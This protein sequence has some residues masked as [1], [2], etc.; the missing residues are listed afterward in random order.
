MAAQLL[1]ERYWQL[2]YHHLY[3]MLVPLYGRRVRVW[4]QVGTVVGGDEVAVTVD[5][6]H[7]GKYVLTSWSQVTLLEDDMDEQELEHFDH[8]GRTFEEARQV[9]RDED[10]RA[11]RD[12]WERQEQQELDRLEQEQEFRR[13]VGVDRGARMEQ[14][15]DRDVDTPEFD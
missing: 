11:M 13:Q 10:Q 1:S 15:F 4:G 7:D 5:V 8:E 2:Y 3:S 14:E 12:E 9:E 6:T